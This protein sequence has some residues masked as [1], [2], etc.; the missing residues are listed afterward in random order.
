[1]EAPHERPVRVR[2]RPSLEVREMLH[3]I[4]PFLAIAIAIAAFFGVLFATQR[5]GLTHPGFMKH[6][7]ETATP[8][9]E[10]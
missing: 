3:K 1:M 4:L 5:M 9:A 7:A 8:E 10:A 6:E 2:L